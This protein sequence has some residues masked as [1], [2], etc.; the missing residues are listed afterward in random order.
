MGMHVLALLWFARASA[1]RCPSEFGSEHTCISPAYIP[2]DSSA[3]MMAAAVSVSAD[4]PLPAS[5]CSGVQQPAR[6]PV[7]YSVYPQSLL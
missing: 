5:R 6:T 4:N 1:P 7:L 3:S 2:S